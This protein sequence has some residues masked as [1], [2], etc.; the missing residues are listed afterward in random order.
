MYGIT[1]HWH[2]PPIVAGK[3]VRFIRQACARPDFRG[4]SGT[5]DAGAAVYSGTTAVTSISTRA[6]SSISAT[7]CTAVI[8]G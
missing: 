5:G 4:S 2:G 1:G 7:T 3:Q 6:R 8:V